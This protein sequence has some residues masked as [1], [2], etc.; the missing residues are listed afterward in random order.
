LQEFRSCRITELDGRRVA[1]NLSR[2]ALASSF[3]NSW[4][5]LGRVFS[6]HRRFSKPRSVALASETRVRARGRLR[7]GNEKDWRRFERPRFDALGHD[8]QSVGNSST[9]SLDPSTDPKPIIRPGK[10]SPPSQSFRNRNRTRSRTRTRFPIPTGERSSPDSLEIEV[11]SWPRSIA[12]T[13][14]I[15]DR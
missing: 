7:L 10:S 1:S 12:W 15:T 13:A 9:R 8:T 14:L 6:S 5:P 3:C 11:V 2:V 4:G